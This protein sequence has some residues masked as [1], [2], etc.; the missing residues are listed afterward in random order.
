MFE[1][2]AIVQVEDRR[3]REL[4]GREGDEVLAKRCAHVAASRY[5]K[6]AYVKDTVRGTLFLIPR[7]DSP[8]ACALA[9][10]I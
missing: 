5:A 1:I 4:I 2:Y 7:A 8:Q 3:H 10:S 9:L 6:Y